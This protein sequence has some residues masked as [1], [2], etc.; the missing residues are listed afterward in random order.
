MVV[1]F[2]SNAS[3]ELTF[4]PFYGSAWYFCASRAESVTFSR[5]KWCSVSRFRFDLLFKRKSE[6]SKLK[7]ATL[8][9]ILQDVMKARNEHFSIFMRPNLIQWLK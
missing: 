1:F 5:M 7:K 2:F 6:C 4:S 9:Q 8:S 3:G